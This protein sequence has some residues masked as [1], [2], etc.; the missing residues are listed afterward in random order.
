MCPHLVMC[1]EGIN[2]RNKSLSRRKHFWLRLS[3][4]SSWMCSYLSWAPNRCRLWTCVDRLENQYSWNQ[5]QSGKNSF[6]K[7]ELSSSCLC[8]VLPHEKLWLEVYI[9]V[10]RLF[11][12][13]PVIPL[14]LEPSIL[15][16]VRLKKKICVPFLPVSPLTHIRVRQKFR[17]SVKSKMTKILKIKK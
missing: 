9:Y 13:A 2:E 17:I 7:A 10:A 1:E 3:E 8:C 16:L 14:K 15:K 6:W 4:K 12:E 11:L 5:I